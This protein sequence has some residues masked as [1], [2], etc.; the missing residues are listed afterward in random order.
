MTQSHPSQ[1]PKN[2]KFNKNGNFCLFAFQFKL[3][4]ASNVDLTNFILI[5]CQ[6]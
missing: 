1:F 5:F 6:K 3:I 2:L 4:I